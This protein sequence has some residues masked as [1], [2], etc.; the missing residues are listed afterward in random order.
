MYPMN[1][2]LTPPFQSTKRGF[3]LIEL[4]TVIAII[5]ILAGILIPVVGSAQR[6]A[7]KA[8][9]KA[10]FNQYAL[11]LQQYRSEYGYWPNIGTLRNGTELNLGTT[12]NSQDFI[13][14]LTGRNPNG[15]DLSDTDRQN[16]NRKAVSFLSISDDQLLLQADGDTDE[17]R[18]VDAFNNPNIKILVDHDN[19]G[20]IPAS[21]LPDSPSNDLNAKVAIWTSQSDGS[22]GDNFEDVRSW[23]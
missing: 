19:N 10:A 11:A 2:R 4:L 5:G 3:T 23:E 20:K 8:K 6:S 22:A 21:R 14:A 16:L 7:N 15:T 13:K 18:L 12:A 1:N 9:S 17:D